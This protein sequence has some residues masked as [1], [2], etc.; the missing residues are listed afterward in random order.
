MPIQQNRASMEGSEGGMLGSFQ[1]LI[2]LGTH[3][4]F[5]IIDALQW[6][7]KFGRL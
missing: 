1:P 6:C 7:Y 2:S 4:M 3:I 5:N